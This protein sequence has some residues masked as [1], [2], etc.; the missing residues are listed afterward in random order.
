[1]RTTTERT[2]SNIDKNADT[3]NVH[4]DHFIDS[5]AGGVSPSWTG[6]WR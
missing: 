1:M 2:Q 4:D 5:D 6:Y 3:Y